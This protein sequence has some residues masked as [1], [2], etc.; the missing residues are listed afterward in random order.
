MVGAEGSSMRTRLAH[1]RRMRLTHQVDRVLAYDT[2]GHVV[3]LAAGMHKKP[4]SG[5]GDTSSGLVFLFALAGGLAVANVYY[6]QPLLEVVADDLDAGV[7]TAGLLVTVTNFGFVLG[8]VFLVPLGDVLN[9]RRLVML[10]F[11]VASAALAAAASAPSIALLASALVVI[12]V[13][14][15]TAQILVPFVSLLARHGDEGKVVGSVMTGLMLGTLVSRSVAGGVAGVVGWRGMYWLGSAVM[16]MLAVALHR[17]LPDLPPAACMRYSDLLRSVAGLLRREPILRRHAAYGAVTFAVFNAFWT[18]L[19]FLLTEPPYEFS[20][21]AIGAVALI[22][23]PSAFIAPYAGQLADRG[24]GPAMTGWYLVLALAGVVAAY[25]GGQHL[26][27]LLVGGFL[28]A[29]SVGCVHVTNQSLIYRLDPAARSRLTTAYMSS[30]FFG[31]MVGSALAAALYA[32]HGW[33][34]VSI[35]SACCTLAVTVAWVAARTRLPFRRRQDRRW[36]PEGDEARSP[37]TTRA[38]EAA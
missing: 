10:L 25:V 15:V 29:F 24:R 22:G 20:E 18:T 3:R 32:A 17:R 4:A 11:F 37:A 13:T 5:G 26:I 27:A 12:G 21:A 34:G 31:G 8:L 19:A 30:Y 7:A 6:I 1:I 33:T 14:S 16:M 28:I 23:I 9:R 35:L 36:V 2:V 38:S